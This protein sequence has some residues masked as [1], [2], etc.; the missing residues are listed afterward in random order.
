MREAL[1]NH[2]A[3]TAFSTGATGDLPHS[4]ATFVLFRRPAGIDFT[5]CL[6]F[7][8]RNPRRSLGGVARK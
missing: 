2:P 8:H 7:K 5:F 3:K 4:E 1:G 6:S